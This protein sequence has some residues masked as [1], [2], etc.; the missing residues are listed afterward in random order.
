MTGDDRSDPFSDMINLVAAPLAGTI[1]SFDQFRRGVDEFLRGVENFNRTME[2]LNETAERINVLLAEVEEPIKAAI[3]QV[4]RAVKAADDMMQV[5]SGP[6]I[7]VAPGLTRLAEVLSTPG[8]NQLP[9]QLSQ[10]TDVMTEM[11]KRLGPLTQFAESAGG[12]FG[13]L[14]LPGMAPARPA[15]S[16]PG[17]HDIVVHERTVEPAPAPTENPAA[18]KAA[19]RKAPAKRAGTKRAPAKKAATKR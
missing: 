19:P 1:R 4:T 5:V 11:S 9:N 8:F 7:A 2:N 13:G 10:F 14:R 12:L 6:A 3:P 15:P 17:S 18:K 16:A